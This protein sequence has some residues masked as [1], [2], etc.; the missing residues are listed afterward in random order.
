MFKRYAKK[1]NNPIDD[2]YAERMVNDVL[3]SARKMNPAKDTLPTF[4]YE[5]LTLG[6]TEEI[7][8]KGNSPFMRD[9]INERIIAAENEYLKQ[10]KCL[11]NF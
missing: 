6:A 5:D 11:Q 4:G 8:F 2:E 1:N 3:S 9:Q 7:S 10:G